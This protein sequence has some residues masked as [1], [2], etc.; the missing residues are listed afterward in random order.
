MAIT[1]TQDR[2]DAGIKGVYSPNW[3][4]ISNTSDTTYFELDVIYNS[5]TKTVRLYPDINIS[6]KVDINTLMI[7]NFQSDALTPNTELLQYE[8]EGRSYFEQY[9]PTSFSGVDASNW[10]INGTKNNYDYYLMNDTDASTLNALGFAPKFLNDAPIMSLAYNENLLP[11]SNADNDLTLSFI[12]KT[13]LRGNATSG[14]E[15]RIYDMTV[16]TYDH[17]NN[18]VDT[19]TETLTLPP[20]NKIINLGIKPSTINSLFGVDIITNDTNYYTIQC[21][22]LTEI[23]RVNI[24]E[25]N[26]L[27]DK[28]F[29]LSW[30]NK[31]GVTNSFNFDYNYQ[32]SLKVSKQTYKTIG[33]DDAE[34][35]AYF[36]TEVDESFVVSS[37][38]I[39]EDEAVILEDL[40]TSPDVICTV[41]YNKNIDY[42]KALVE[43]SL[44]VDKKIIL[45]L[46]T[47]TIQRRRIDKLI[48][49]SVKFFMSDIYRNQQQ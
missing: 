26:L 19:L 45:D 3:V 14:S 23:V 32:K 21:D 17:N 44:L 2:S 7:D 41:F 30:I 4:S 24:K 47:V 20:P 40:W 18:L 39:S 48:N 25:P 42:N 34:Q 29:R 46:K 31:N 5:I 37:G 28:Y 15:S 12:N 36:N 16:T 10:V 38:Y 35:N 22:D 43:D 27:N 13:F 8:I 49:Y 1:L 6:V 11:S 9:P 33:T